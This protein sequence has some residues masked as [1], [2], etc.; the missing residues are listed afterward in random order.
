MKE[1]EAATQTEPEEAHEVGAPKAWVEGTG[2]AAWSGMVVSEKVGR[3]QG[4]AVAAAMAG[5]VVAAVGKE[6]L[7]AAA[8]MG[9]GRQ[10]GCREAGE[11]VE[12]GRAARRER[13]YS[14][15]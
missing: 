2:E 9:V 7:L 15:G 3:E 11:E 10:Q 14:S 4:A 13:V 1:V 5:A 8:G 6:S 12:I